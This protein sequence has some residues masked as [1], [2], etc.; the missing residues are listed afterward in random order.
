MKTISINT[1]KLINVKNSKRTEANDGETKTLY[2]SMAL[3]ESDT[4]HSSSKLP[5]GMISLYSFRTSSIKHF[6]P[7]FGILNTVGGPVVFLYDI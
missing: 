7:Q 2:P 1:A 3:M 5:V 4:R 6:V